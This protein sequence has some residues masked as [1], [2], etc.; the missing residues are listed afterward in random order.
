MAALPIITYI[1]TAIAALVGGA[2]VVESI[3]NVPGMGT[4]IF[5]AVTRRDYS[6]LQGATVLVAV[7][8]V[9]LNIVVDMLYGVVDPRIRLS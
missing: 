5:Q 6:E 8:I 9:A 3:F 4:L 7:L 2:V 1:G